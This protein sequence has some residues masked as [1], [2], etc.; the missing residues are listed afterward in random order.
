MADSLSNLWNRLQSGSQLRLSAVD[1]DAL[2]QF[3]ETLEQ[4]AD[5]SAAEVAAAA[6]PGADSSNDA[7]LPPRQEQA[8]SA[9][10]DE[11]AVTLLPVQSSDPADEFAT[12]IPI[13]QDNDATLAPAKDATNLT[14]AASAG[15]RVRYF[16]DYELL[17][18]IARGG[19]GVVYRAQ[20]VNLNRIV[21]LKMILAGNLASEEEV[22]RFRTEAEAAANLDHPGI[23]PIYEIG[24]HEG[25]HFFSMGY[26][27][28]CSL[29]D[30]L[31][32]GPL[33]PKLAA[34]FTRKIAEAIAYA[35]ENGV[36]HRDLKPANV[37]LDR[38]GEPRVTDFGLARKTDTDSGLTKTGAVMGT[39]SYMPPEQAAGKTNEVGPLS[40]VYSLGAILYCLLTGRPP[41]QAASPIDTLMQVME[42]EPVSIR[43]LSPKVPKDLETISLKCLQKDRGRRY[44][45]ARHLVADIERWQRGEPITAR[46]VST[47][48][49]TW[50]WV[51]RNR[52]ISGLI[53]GTIAAILIGSVASLWF[54]LAAKVAESKAKV[55]EANA[56]ASEA[57]A[58]FTLAGVELDRQRPLDAARHLHDVPKQYRQ[59][60]WDLA[61][62]RLTTGDFEVCSHS[63]SD[64]GVDV[65][66]FSPDGRLIA[67]AS[68][69]EVIVSDAKTL[70]II[71]RLEV[72]EEWYRVR[73]VSF[74]VDGRLLA[75]AGE[76]FTASA[77]ELKNET[78]IQIFDLESAT[79]S[80][81]ISGIDWVNNVEFSPDG[82]EIG[83]C[84][85]S[86]FRSSVGGSDYQPK[87][88]VIVFS[89]PSGARKWS[90][91]DWTEPVVGVQYLGDKNRILVTTTQKVFV[92]RSQ[93]EKEE[94]SIKAWGLGFDQRC[95][96]SANESLAISKDW[97]GL[98]I[99]DFS[100]GET[101]KKIPIESTVFLDHLQFTA[102]GSRIV[103][104]DGSRRLVVWTVRDG[105]LEQESDSETSPITTIS[106]CP[107]GRRLVSGHKNGL[108]KIWRL[109]SLKSRGRLLNS[110]VC[111]LAASSADG[112]LLW[113][114]SNNSIC[115]WDSEQGTLIHS[116]PLNKSSWPSAMCVDPETN[117]AVLALNAGMG[118]T[119][120]TQKTQK[121]AVQLWDLKSGKL[122]HEFCRNTAITPFITMS[123]DGRR[124]AC[125]MADGSVS[126]W[127]GISG[128]LV[129]RLP[130]RDSQ[131]QPDSIGKASA[132]MFLPDGKTL[133]A[134]SSFSLMRGRADDWQNAIVSPQKHNSGIEC[135]CTSQ[136]GQLIA[137]GDQGG[138]IAIWNSRTMQPVRI[139]QD[140]GEGGAKV[141]R[142]TFVP[143]QQRLVS[144]NAEDDLIIWD[145]RTGRD[146]FR[147]KVKEAGQ[148]YGWSNSASAIC[149]ND[150]LHMAVGTPS[151]LILVNAGLHQS[152]LF[153]T[154]W[155]VSRL[156]FSANDRTLVA[157]NEDGSQLVAWDIT[158]GQLLA[159]P[160]HG[161]QIDDVREGSSDRAWNSVL[162]DNPRIVHLLPAEADAVQK[163][164]APAFFSDAKWHQSGAE[165]ARMEQ[166]WYTAV[167]HGAWLLRHNPSDAWLHDDVHEDLRKLKLTNGGVAPP[168]H[169][170]AKTALELPRGTDLPQLNED[171]ADG[172][173]QQIWELLKRP[174]VEGNSTISEWH[175]QRMQ[176]VCSRFAQGSY[177]NT[178]GVL[179][180]RL[181]RF[182]DAIVSLNK[183]IELSPAETGDPAP[184]P[185]DLGFLAMSYFKANDSIKSNE[186]YDAFRSTASLANWNLQPDIQRLIDEVETTL[187][188]STTGEA[189]VSIEGFNREATF[190]GLYRHHWQFWPS[191]D[192][193]GAFGLVYHPAYSQTRLQASSQYGPVMAY[194]AVT[195]EPNTKYR[196]TG[197]LR[198]IPPTQ[199]AAPSQ[200]SSTPI[201]GASIGLLNRPETS[202]VISATTDWK[203]VTFEFTTTETETTV[204]PGFRLGLEG[205][206]IS[207]TAW[208]DDLKLEKVDADH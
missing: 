47:T 28:G 188:K 185:L 165:K 9:T 142:M 98:S 69:E 125:S 4:A 200:P 97:N 182:E 137:S 99:E 57:K 75:V 14:S 144:I 133:I 194:Q 39:P 65:V 101:V 93:S 149:L 156:G 53:T 203:Q 16:G 85:G 68:K 60:E 174:A 96:V 171:S 153:H 58:I 105:I 102:D 92:V 140:G 175:L 205:Q 116:Y 1:R 80:I 5:Q 29:A 117:R 13:N 192:Y 56:K 76:G 37:L 89:V 146:L 104:V 108:V 159:E 154:D 106:T 103:G 17:S 24:Q 10:V 51:K 62:S 48:E 189:A 22:Q 88:S 110:D 195:V 128:N 74:S 33:P 54:G 43:L 109:N 83:A 36:I 42:K 3:F 23:V 82:T 166:N 90:L 131:E 123:A 18:E 61:N 63:A 73:D 170:I 19:M 11:D 155:P 59:V 197:R 32:Y 206:P 100:S 191:E 114:Y 152:R 139:L 40:D 64:S 94:L 183:S 112:K 111:Q 178:L 20:Q 162:S 164:Q 118:E 169:F 72:P 193:A 87:N 31:K 77:A 196:L 66:K 8:V 190:E 172:L 91:D 135:L 26:V 145:L 161:L 45:S 27:D 130:I 35:H 143:D 184:S 207:G 44:A 132:L 25:Q 52:M 41:F 38:S 186:V 6:M 70:E 78:Q 199:P 34:E 124:I 177:F 202:E 187:Q 107:E 12:V 126:V 163:K 198:Y 138:R 168:F 84:T 151:G 201:P 160:P 173:Y 150:K 158:T 21:A 134:T 7:T 67:S 127:D 50:R 208:F 115:A 180:Y 49:R 46:A 136:D 181:G 86:P 81:R 30:R 113:G 129:H 148:S 176:D 71:R 122:L 95:P 157:A 179:Q 121:G 120:G 147:M 55:S 167:F 15:S 204:S 79:I 119:R 141:R 2:K